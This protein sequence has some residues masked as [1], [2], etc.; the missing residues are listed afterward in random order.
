MDANLLLTITFENDFISRRD[1]LPMINDINN[2]N[3]DAVL[4]RTSYGIANIRAIT[5]NLGIKRHATLY[6]DNNDD[7]YQLQ[8]I[9]NPK[10]YEENTNS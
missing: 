3:K 4:Y 6:A 1:V 8:L 7:F 5:D 10:K 2:P 9:F